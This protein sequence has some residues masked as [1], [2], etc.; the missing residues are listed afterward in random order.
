MS[1]IGFRIGIGVEKVETFD[2]SETGESVHAH[3]EKICDGV[4]ICGN[5]TENVDELDSG[6]KQM[7]CN[8][9]KS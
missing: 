8:G 1:A 2:V 4:M 3:D 5:W 7:V 9:Y 6:V